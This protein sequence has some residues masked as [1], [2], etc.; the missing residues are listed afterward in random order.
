ME[1]DKQSNKEIDE[2]TFLK[3]ENEIL[4]MRLNNAM[5]FIQMMAEEGFEKGRRK[6]DKNVDNN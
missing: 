1:H 6:E 4:R 3:S 2:L 5:T